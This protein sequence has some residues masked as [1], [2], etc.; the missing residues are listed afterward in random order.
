MDTAHELIGTLDLGDGWCVGI[1]DCGWT[2]PNVE[3]RR[4][5]I[6]AVRIHTILRAYGDAL[7]PIDRPA[8]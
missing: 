1:C 5:A 7:S 3:G 6:E 2:S 4:R 8:A